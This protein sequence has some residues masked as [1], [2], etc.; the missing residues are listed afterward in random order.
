MSLKYEAM[1][2]SIIATEIAK[3]NSLPAGTYHFT[4]EKSEFSYAVFGEENSGRK[5]NPFLVLNECKLKMGEDTW[6]T[7]SEGFIISLE[8][9]QDAD[10]YSEID[11]AKN[12]GYL[13]SIRRGLGERADKAL[14]INLMPSFKSWKII[15]STVREVRINQICQSFEKLSPAVQA[16]CIHAMR[17]PSINPQ[18][19]IA[20]KDFQEILSVAADETLEILKDD[21]EGNSD[22]L[23]LGYKSVL[24]K[25]PIRLIPIR[26]HQ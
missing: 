24:V 16:S 6:P 18:T 14:S 13:I 7:P 10:C 9:L 1:L 23:P 21:F 20:F 11:T 19:G 22:L 8:S 4:H 25:N 26:T 12:E 5:N 17:V 15:H 2:I 3:N